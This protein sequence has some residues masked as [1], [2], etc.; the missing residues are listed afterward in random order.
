MIKLLF[1]LFFITCT[2]AT[3]NLPNPK[4]FFWYNEE[5]IKKEQSEK[6]QE[7]VKPVSTSSAKKSANERMKEYQDS[8]RE[9]FNEA[10]L[11]PTYQNVR[12]ARAVYEEQFDNGGEFSDVWIQ[13]EQDEGHKFNSILS[14][15]TALKIVKEQTLQK[16]YLT[17]AKIAKTHGL[18]Y[19][20]YGKCPVCQAWAKQ[21]KEFASKFG[22]E[23]EGICAD[24]EEINEFQKADSD[25]SLIK[26]FNPDGVVKPY[27]FLMPKGEGDKIVVIGNGM[28]TDADLVRNIAS[29]FKDLGHEK[30]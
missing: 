20:F 2:Q 26:F 11:N 21:V 23:I 15:N 4:G 9:V 16:K 17:I 8:I 19:L 1:A 10:M 22:F 12:K 13:V 24:G 27:L 18:V 7:V 25:P 3:L 29:R 30:I 28:V 6:K 14:N 5:D